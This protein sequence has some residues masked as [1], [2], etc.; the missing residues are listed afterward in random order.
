MTEGFALELAKQTMNELGVG[1]NYLIR[2]RHFQIP[3]ASKIEL[4]AQNE[5]L[6]IIKPNRFL[7]VYSKA[8]IYNELDNR[9]NEMQYIHRGRTTIINQLK[10]DYL[11][12][13][14][15]QVIPKLKTIK[16]GKHISK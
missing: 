9:I 13:K 7:K 11:Q 10:K 15:L 12:V 14:I 16:N 1:E 3:P 2:F 5:L 4:K 8:G 6:I